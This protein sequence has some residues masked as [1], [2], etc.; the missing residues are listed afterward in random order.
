MKH[1]DVRE[2][3]SAF[4]I[5]EQ[6]RVIN[7]DGAPFYTSL[8]SIVSYVFEHT[9]A[10][11]ERML[12]TGEITEVIGGP[13]CFQGWIYWRYSLQIKAAAGRYKNGKISPRTTK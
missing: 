11:P 12:K 8:Q 2:L 3:I 9:L 13:I 7:P 6:I 10:P 1:S 5:G 4:R